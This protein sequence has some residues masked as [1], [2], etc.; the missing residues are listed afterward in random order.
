MPFCCDHRHYMPM[1]VIKLSGLSMAPIVNSYHCKLY[2]LKPVDCSPIVAAMTQRSAK[3][4]CRKDLPVVVSLR[5][6]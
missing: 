2:N 1:A 3:R 4:V 6:V 5:M